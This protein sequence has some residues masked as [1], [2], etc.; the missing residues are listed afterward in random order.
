MKKETKWYGVRLPEGLIKDVEKTI[1]KS[2][3]W[4]SKDF[5]QGCRKAA[6]ELLWWNGARKGEKVG[7]GARRGI[8]YKAPGLSGAK[9]SWGCVFC[10][11]GAL[12]MNL[13][14]A[15]N[16][17]VS[18]R[19]YG[20]ARSDYPVY[21]IHI[22]HWDFYLLDDIV[23]IFHFFFHLTISRISYQGLSSIQNMAFLYLKHAVKL[24]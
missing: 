16:E 10:T 22:V 4:S 2:P 17:L 13:H 15:F 14:S 6:F 20:L 18:W 7:T 9:T 8:N 21:F 5:C 1:E 11:V 3:H 23:E 19:I 24:N 12:Q